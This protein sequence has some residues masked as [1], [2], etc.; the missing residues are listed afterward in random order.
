MARH[1]KVTN[2]ERAATAPGD[3]G[4][5]LAARGLEHSFGNR[6]VLRGVD[7]ELRTGEIVALLGPNGAGKTTLMSSL[8]GLLKPHR[9]EV[10]CQCKQ[11]GWVPQ[12]RSTYARLTVRENIVLFTKLLRLPGNPQQIA[13]AAA[14]EADLEPWLDHLCWELSGGLRQRLNVVVGLL[15]NPEVIVLDEPTTGVDLV[16]RTAL[17]EQLRRGRGQGRA[18]MYSTHTIEDAEVADRAVVLVDGCIAWSGPVPELAELAPAGSE[19]DPVAAGLLQL[20]G[21][22]HTEPAGGGRR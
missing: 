15:G 19:G 8:V 6:Q 4:V 18:A 10:T 2:D 1:G 3:A 22:E 7:L 12:G 13:E 21:P 11:V 5:V 14:R 20:W 17:W 16:H 9:G